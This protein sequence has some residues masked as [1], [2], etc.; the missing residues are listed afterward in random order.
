MLEPGADINEVAI[1][2]Y[3]ANGVEKQVE[4]IVQG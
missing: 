3:A 1:L 2:V 4:N